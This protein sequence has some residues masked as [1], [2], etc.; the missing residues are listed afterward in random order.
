MA[1]L[2]RAR[3]SHFYVT[4]GFSNQGNDVVRNFNISKEGLKVLFQNGFRDGDSFPSELFHELYEQDHIY[5]SET[6]SNERVEPPIDLHK[7]VR[8]FFNQFDMNRSDSDEELTKFK[9]IVV[10]LLRIPSSDTKT[11]M[12]LYI[13]MQAK[14]LPDKFKNILVKNCPGSVVRDFKMFFNLTDDVF[15]KIR[16]GDSMEHFIDDSDKEHEIKEPEGAEKIKKT[17]LPQNDEKIER[18]IDNLNKT[19][20][21]CFSEVKRHGISIEITIKIAQEKLTQL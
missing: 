10:E 7:R 16:S 14:G 18:I 5:S 1:R 13:G 3:D 21:S 8:D 17:E 15:E 2:N 11:Q 12:F 20:K 9:S 6:P 19:L 4:H